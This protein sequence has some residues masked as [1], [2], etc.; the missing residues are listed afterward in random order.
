MSKKIWTITGDKFLSIEQVS[1]LIS[2]LEDQKD[3]ALSRNTLQPV[4]D[5]YI[6]T[7]LLQTGL[8]CFE[9]C[10]LKNSDIQNTK[11][12]VR[13][14]KGNK[15]RTV[16]LTKQTAELLKTW[17]NYLP[18]YGYSQDSDAPFMPNRYGGFNSTR[19]IRYRVKKALKAASLPSHLSV[20]SL[21]H[22]NCS[23]LLETK[24][25]SLARI[26]DNLGHSSINIVNIYAHAVGN[27]DE[28]DLFD[29][30]SDFSKK[31]E[32]VNT[33]K[34]LNTRKKVRAYTRKRKEKGTNWI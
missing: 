3:I 4:K 5:Y 9:F 12:V 33:K 11:L 6:V 34:E 24:K 13:R 31:S 30:I 25:V 10:S 32:Q 23:L 29:S 8:R 17:Q 28:V 15:P 20:H 14:G 26:R 1:K 16:L 7:V 22:T 21:R 27:L 18:Q 2:Y 19:A